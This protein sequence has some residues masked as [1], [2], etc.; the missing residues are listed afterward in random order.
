VVAAVGVEEAAVAVG[1]GVGAVTV[2]E[3]DVV[4]T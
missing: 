3:E 2:I 1:L 4:D